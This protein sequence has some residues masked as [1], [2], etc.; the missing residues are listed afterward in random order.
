MI[1]LRSLAFALALVLITPPYSLL[2]LATFPLPRL[3]RFRIIT[4]WNRIV[5]WLA[6]TVLGIRYTVTGGERLPA[7]P[8]IILSKHQSAW[9]TI[10]FP[11]IFPPQ[12]IVIKRELLWIPFFGWG[13]AL[14]SPIAIDRSRGPAALKRMAGI[15][16]RRLDQGFWISVFP[17]GTRTRP[18][19]RRPYQLGGAWLAVQ[20]GAPVVPVAHNAGLLWGKNAFLKRPGTVTVEIGAPIESAGADPHAVNAAVERWIEGRMAALCPGT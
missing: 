3:L 5:I 14:T 7:G 8:A 15:G 20:C 4:G 10:A 6:R 2:S 11:V 12:V 13:L 16:K 17:E 18:G 9:E 1:F 19:E